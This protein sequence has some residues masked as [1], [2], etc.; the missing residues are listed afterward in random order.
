M[1]NSRISIYIDFALLIVTVVSAVCAFLA[2]RHQKNRSKKEAAC[3]LAKY[4]AKNVISR[5]AHICTVLKKSK[6]A[7]I[8]KKCFPLSSIKEFN[9]KEMEELLEESG[10]TEEEIANRI[11]NIDPFIILN[12]NLVKETSVLERT[13]IKLGYVVQDEVTGEREIINGDFLQNDFLQEIIDT[14]NE[15][16]WFSMN[17]KYRIADE[18]ILYQS[19]HQTFLSMVWMLYYFISRKNHSN[20][21]KTYTNVIWLFCIW[22]DRLAE[23]KR[24]PDVKRN[25]LHR[26]QEKLS[27]KM[28]KTDSKVFSGRKL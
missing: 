22:R 25:R 11:S 24:R 2:Y 27:Q 16:E 18:E 17:C 7:E 6:I 9:M 13:L 5:Y 15:L 23:I 4:Y 1:E 19:L 21:D 26:K 8:T 10:E 3:N 20:P 12:S 14:L 28:K